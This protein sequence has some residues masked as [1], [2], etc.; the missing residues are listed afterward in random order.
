MF[1]SLLNAGPAL[2]CEIALRWWLSELLPLVPSKVLAFLAIGDKPEMLAMQAMAKLENGPQSVAEFA[3]VTDSEGR[4]LVY[5]CDDLFHTCTIELPLVPI[6]QLS[7]L[8]EF[9]SHKYNP[10]RSSD[11]MFD[12][13]IAARDLVGR[14]IK[15]NLFFFRRELL[16]TARASAAAAGLE[17]RG[18]LVESGGDLQQLEHLFGTQGLLVRT[19]MKHRRRLL[20]VGAVAFC[21]TAAMTLLAVRLHLAESALQGEVDHLR[22]AIRQTEPDR[23]A[24]RD[25][26]AEVDAINNA[27]A[28][29]MAIHALDEIT[30]LL[31]DST[32]ATRADI[33]SATIEIHGYS[34]RAADLID[35]FAHSPDFYDAHFNGPITKD[36]RS[37]AEQFNLAVKVR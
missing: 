22:Q 1:R 34:Q 33:D 36:P 14:R 26:N 20:K 6:F 8:I 11:S 25:L 17:L 23:R 9:E 24:L 5:F 16:E 12:Y 37:H 18:A 29:S 7:N 27:R 31:P 15:L 3:F 4:A 13:C 19:A 21:S 2:S 35:T 32:W 10:M 30:H 28:G